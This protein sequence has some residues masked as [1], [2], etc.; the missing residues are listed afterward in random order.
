MAIRTSN[1]YLNANKTLQL[2]A[3]T[4]S[5]AGRED[6]G[7]GLCVSFSFQIG[8]SYLIFFFFKQ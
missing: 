6:L 3:I 1:T 4:A 2:R 7:L 5:S 8:I